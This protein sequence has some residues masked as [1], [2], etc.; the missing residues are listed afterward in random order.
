MAETDLVL[1]N[2]CNVTGVLSYPLVRKANVGATLTSM[3]MALQGCRRFCYISSLSALV[4]GEEAEEPVSCQDFL[5]LLILPAYGASK[6]VSEILVG[7]CAPRLSSCCIFRPGSIG[8][9]QT[10]GALSP[11]DTLARYMIGICELGRAPR[12]PGCDISVIPVDA[13]AG[14]IVDRMLVHGELRVIHLR[15]EASFS[16]EDIAAA[17][18]AS[19]VPAIETIPWGKFCEIVPQSK[20]LGPLRGYFKASSHFPMGNDSLGAQSSVAAPRVTK[21]SLGLY[22]QWLCQK[23]LLLL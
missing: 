6:R 14:A 3:R 15:G 13:V 23:N 11:N 2:G 17:A 10:C 16:V 19:A 12:L 20:S 9:S 8:G 22:F 18:A 1:H 21:E 5:T 4:S 7:M